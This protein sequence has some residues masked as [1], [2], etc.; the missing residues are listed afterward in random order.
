MARQEIMMKLIKEKH[1]SATESGS[2]LSHFKCDRIK[3]QYERNQYLFVTLSTK[4]K[5]FAVLVHHFVWMYFMGWHVPKLIIIHKDNNKKNNNINNLAASTNA[6][7]LQ[8]TYDS[9]RRVAK[10]GV[11]NKN[12]KLSNEQLVLIRNEKVLSSRE[13]AQKFGVGKTT[14]LNAIRYISYKDWE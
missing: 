9:G 1:Y 7:N 12:S 10:A 5:P 14:I 11:D 8:R 4:D 2:I 13:Q 6:T 3:V